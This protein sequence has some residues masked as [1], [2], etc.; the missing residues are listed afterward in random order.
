MMIA[1]LALGSNL[2]NPRLQLE[3]A[4]SELEGLKQTRVLKRS[5]F[6]RTRPIGVLDQPEFINA[7]VKIETDLTP[8][9]LLSGVLAIE[10]KHHRIRHQKNGPRTLDIDVLL[11]GNQCMRECELELPHPR[12]KER[13]FVIYPLLEIDKALI[14]P[15]GTPISDL[16]EKLDCS[17]IQIMSSNDE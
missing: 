9:K 5:S 12:M 4:F 17:G 11:Y 6:Y 10:N 8:M 15:C 13:A 3:T 14:L 1:Y 7:V 2:E 16:A